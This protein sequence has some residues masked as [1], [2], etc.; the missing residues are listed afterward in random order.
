MSTMTNIKFEQSSS[1]ARRVEEPATYIEDGSLA[2]D[3]VHAE[4]PY[5]DGAGELK[6][7]PGTEA[8]VAALG[9]V[10]AEKAHEVGR[11]YVAE[12]QAEL[13]RL[14]GQF[15]DAS[16]E[17]AEGSV[18]T[19]TS[20]ERLASEVKQA[21]A[22]KYNVSSEDFSLFT[23]EKDGETRKTVVYTGANGIDLGDPKEDYDDARSWHKV[24]DNSGQ[25]KARHIVTI[26]GVEYDD[27]KGMTY[28]LYDQLVADA[29]AADRPLPDSKDTMITS[30]SGDT[31][32]SWTMMSGEPLTAMGEAP[33]ARVGDVG[34]MVRGWTFRGNDA[35]DLRF[36]PAVNLDDL[37]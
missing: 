13:D 26:D 15:G 17:I 35:V 36:R 28:A 20:L 12:K 34:S 9:Q 5:R 25:N 33:I 27:R 32:Y 29:K 22:E 16:R 19:E 10:A 24:M 6:K 11:A 3:M 18:E 37:R 30:N 1:S 31:W 7:L 23:Y 4:K 8:A 21:L 2:R 14:R